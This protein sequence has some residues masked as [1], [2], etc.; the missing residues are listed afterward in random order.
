[1]VPLFTPGWSLLLKRSARPTAGACHIP[2]PKPSRGHPAIRFRD[3][4]VGIGPPS[5]AS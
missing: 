1:M 3:Y 2:V 4:L 5:P